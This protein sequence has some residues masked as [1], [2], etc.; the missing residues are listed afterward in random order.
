MAKGKK[1]KNRGHPAGKSAA[2]PARPAA[3][4]P[5][6]SRQALVVG[7]VVLI[8]AG[9]VAFLVTGSGDDPEQEATS[10]P[11]DLAVPWVDAQGVTPT[12]GSV[13]INPADDSVWFSSN[14]GMWRVPSDG[15]EPE[16][17]T[18]RLSTNSGEGDISEQLILRFRDPD[19][20][21]A[22]GHPPADSVLPPA[23][24]MIES[25]D[26]G[27]TW[28][29]ISGLGQT[30]FHAIQLSGDVIVAGVFDTAAVSLSRDGGKT[31]EER[32]TPDPLV[33]LEADPESPARLIASTQQGVIGSAD[34][35][36]T[37]RERDRVPNVRFTW[38]EPD[39]L[40]RV[41]P[42]GPVKFSAD[43]GE[44]WEDRG[45]TGGEPQAMFADSADH[46]LVALIDGTIKESDDAGRTWTDFVTP[47]RS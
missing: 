42:G 5:G 15:G 46:L 32:I 9:V 40:Y 3:D 35:G 33:D 11:Q 45:T 25:D 17:I 19:R 24:G 36:Q 28:S 14:T 39:A 44:T 41:D 26:G 12:V 6:L 31:F 21:I 37:W 10:D 8:L 18:G 7:L 23:L 38:P 43:G 22:S 27:A 20:L 13:D 34:E 2:P 1:K 29:E 30:D 16:Q 4:R 47:P